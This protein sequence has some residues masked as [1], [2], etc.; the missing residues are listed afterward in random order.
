MIDDQ[1]TPDEEKLIAQVRATAKPKLDPAAR[2]AIRRQ[3]LSEFRALPFQRPVARFPVRRMF[4]AAAVIVMIG[5]IVLFLTN[6]PPAPNIATPASSQVAVIASET[7]VLPSQTPIML[8]ETPTAVLTLETRGTMT[9]IPP[10]I[11]PPPETDTALPP[12]ATLETTL[13]IEGPITNMVGNIISVYGFEVEVEPQH[14]ILSVIDIGDVI[15]IQGAFS[16][17]GKV[18]ASVV[19]NLTN[20]TGVS[21]EVTVGLE[22]PIESIDGSIIVINDISVE[23]APDDPILQSIQVGNFVRVEGNFQTKESMIVLVVVNIVIIN[24]VTAPEYDCWYHEGG[25]GMGHWHCDGM[26]MGMGEAM[27]MGDAMGM[28]N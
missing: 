21:A 9:P 14:P 4:A 18:I 28:G 25:M 1:F 26:G 6:Q 17:D 10:T 5:S 16:S 3:M 23:L 8:S 19:G 27:G 2:D 12:T 11:L 20:E 24:N 22:G 15:H 13:I 7:P